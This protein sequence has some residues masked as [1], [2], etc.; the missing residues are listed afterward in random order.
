MA[1]RELVDFEKSVK[2]SDIFT[3]HLLIKAWHSYIFFPYSTQY[4]VCCFILKYNLT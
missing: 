2:S 1:K 3:F 4:H